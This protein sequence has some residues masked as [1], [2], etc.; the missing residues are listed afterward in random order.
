MD[1]KIAP[2]MT[3]DDDDDDE[4]D[5]NDEDNG[6]RDHTAAICMALAP[7]KWRLLIALH[8]NCLAL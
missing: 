3:D 6:S 7:L 1:I 5:D 8:F 4:C 2:M